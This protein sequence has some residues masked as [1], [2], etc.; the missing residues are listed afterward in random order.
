MATK[1]RVTCPRCNPKPKRGDELKQYRAELLFRLLLRFSCTHKK[2]AES[3][4]R[5]W[6]DPPK[7]PTCGDRPKVILTFNLGLDFGTTPCEVL[8]VFSPVE[9]EHW[10]KDDDSADVRF[11]PFLVVLRRLKEK[12][13]GEKETAW[14]PYW[15]VVHPKDGGEPKEK[16]GQ[17]APLM[18]QKHVRSL[19]EQAGRAGYDLSKKAT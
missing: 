5:D 13:D 6:L 17:W 7:C 15:H 3:D 2:K 14:F 9:I 19:L 1:R 16:Y 4:A 18:R 12:H 8:D 11:F 10:P